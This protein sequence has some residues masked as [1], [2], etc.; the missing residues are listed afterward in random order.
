MSA[1]KQ[2][3]RLLLAGAILR[4]GVVRGQA[5]GTLP[6][7]TRSANAAPCVTQ[8][9]PQ[10][11]KR[12]GFICREKARIE[13]QMAIK[14]CKASKGDVCDLPDE[15]DLG[16][17][18]PQGK[19]CPVPVT[20][21]PGTPNTKQPAT[22][23]GGANAAESNDSK[24][25]IS[26]DG[27]HLYVCPR[28]SSKVADWPYCETAEHSIVPMMEIPVPPGSLKQSTPPIATPVI[29]APQNQNQATPH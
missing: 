11:P 9:A 6:P 28:G 26:D 5:T 13:R 8:P 12:C 22:V 18:T 27:K 29:G 25:V 16:A 21:P 10:A 24:P 23:I 7:A 3:M 1:T 2:I 14:A 4:G 19:P 15:T 17:I 20:P